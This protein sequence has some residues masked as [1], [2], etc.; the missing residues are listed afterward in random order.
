MHSLEYA[1]ACQGTRAADSRC[2]RAIQWPLISP[3]QESMCQGLGMR[4]TSLSC[5]PITHMAGQASIYQGL[6]RQFASWAASGQEH[7]TTSSTTPHHVHQGL[8]G[9]SGARIRS[10]GPNPEHTFYLRH[11]TGLTVAEPGFVAALQAGCWAAAGSQ[12]PAGPVQGSGGSAPAPSAAAWSAA[13]PSWRA[14]APDPA[15]ADYLHQAL[16]PQGLMRALFLATHKVSRG[17][18]HTELK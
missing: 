5:H 11:R 7:Q 3:A 18:C 12:C 2:A 8:Q 13:C 17:R 16:A 15:S 4:G 14:H 9:C 10:L 6:L 1:G